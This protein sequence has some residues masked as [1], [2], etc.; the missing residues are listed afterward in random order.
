VLGEENATRI[1]KSPRDS[2]CRRRQ[3]ARMRITLPQ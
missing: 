3:L 2:G 1:P